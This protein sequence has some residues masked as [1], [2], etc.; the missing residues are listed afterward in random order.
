MTGQS[1]RM[2]EIEERRCRNEPDPDN[3][4]HSLPIHL[5]SGVYTA[6]K[7]SL[8]HSF[9][10]IVYRARSRSQRRRIY[11]TFVF[12]SCL[13]FLL[14]FT[15]Q[16][17][18][19]DTVDTSYS[20]ADKEGARGFD[21]PHKAAELKLL[22]NGANDEEF[23]DDGGEDLKPDLAPP[24]IH[25]LWCGQKKFEFRHYLSIKRAN[26]IIK[27]DKIFFHY[28]DMPLL[29]NE[30]YY[31]WFNQTRFENDHIL[32]KKLNAT[33]CPQEGAERY[34][35]VLSILE[36]F[37]GIYIPEDALVVDFPIH[38]RAVQ[39][40]SGVVAKSLS[41]Y[42]EGVI[43]AKKNGFISPS[44]QNGLNIVLAS[45]RSAAQGTIE[46]CGSIEHYNKEG[47][48]DCICVLVKDEIYPSSIWDLQTNFGILS[49]LSAYGV[50][51]VEPNFSKKTT[52]PKIAHYICW[53][54][55]LKFGAFL[56]ILS[57]L[58]VAGLSKVYVHGI[59]PPSGMWWK[60]L[61]ETGR[62]IHVY[63]EYPEMSHE[64]GAMTQELAQGIMRMTILL[65]YGGV[66][67]DSKVIWTNQIPDELFGYEA[68][69]SPDW[70]V[71]GSW[72]DS[73]SHT[74]MM[75]KKNSEYLY[76]LRNLHKKKRLESFWFVDQ[77]LAY[78]IL[79][80]SPTV[81][82]FDRHFQVKCLSHNCHPTWHA[83]Y[84][85]SLVENMPGPAFDWFNE[86]LSVYWDVFPEVELDTVKYTSGPIVDAARRVLQK[87]GIS[88]Q[89]LNIR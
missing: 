59:K 82:K 24:I 31:T 51:S 25:Y 26:Y 86:T 66:Y 56:S 13:L 19:I 84:K 2:D 46:P 9:Y 44:S 49:R 61:Q 54:C 67:C 85:T 37:G 27:P 35:L 69:A 3:H 74:S 55:E 22:Q 53:D 65:K 47:E 28:L 29:D 15:Q 68:V 81:L 71:Y 62:V 39:F 75:A 76:R 80:Q 40:M 72:P 64:R 1:L 50:Q 88:L 78:K 30:Q 38:L 45:G 43:V 11:A 58:N 20:E 23:G 18:S 42:S 5:L 63:R 87:S 70:R 34:M 10:R 57:A 21:E 73:V 60:I 36:Y 79:E 17:N 8:L 83:N 41:V 33:W 48:D 16:Q 6:R 12:I 7:E 4:K 52:I 77:F 89:V 32:L 14:I